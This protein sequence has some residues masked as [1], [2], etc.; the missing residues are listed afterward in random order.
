MKVIAACPKQANE[1]LAKASQ[2]K[3]PPLP[4]RVTVFEAKD[5]KVQIMRLNTGLLA[6][7]MQGETAKVLAQV[8]A[9]EEALLQGIVP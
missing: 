7:G 2:G 4:C 9:E 5:G 8:A 3:T 1:Q 6:K